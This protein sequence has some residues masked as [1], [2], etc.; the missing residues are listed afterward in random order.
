MTIKVLQLH[1]RASIEYKFIQDRYSI[2]SSNSVIALADGST[3]SFKS[4][5]W[6]NLITSKFAKNPSFTQED[7]SSQL[8]LA[9]NELQT[10]PHPLSSNPAIASLEKAKKQK[11]STA[12]FLG[13]QILSQKGFR[14]IFCGDTNLF[15]IH[16]DNTITAFPFTDVENLDRNSKFINTE[17][18]LNGKF[19]ESSLIDKEFSWEPND[20]VVLCTDALSRLILKEPSVLTE[21][22]NI[23]SFEEFL[24]FCNDKWNNRVLEEDDISAII[25]SN[26]DGAS[27]TTLVP[28]SNFSFPKAE[29]PEFTPT[30][31]SNNQ[32]PNNISAM[33][34]S[35]IMN[36]FQGVAK[37]FNQI[38]QKLKFHQLL[39]FATIF[40]LIFNIAFTYIFGK[41]NN[42]NS[43]VHNGT[44]QSE[45]A[46][47]NFKLTSELNKSQLENKALKA[48][49]SQMS[50]NNSVAVVDGTTTENP[51]NSSTK[52]NTTNEI[53]AFQ[54]KHGLKDDGS[55]GPASEK[56][57][58][59]LNK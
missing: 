4:E 53:K 2:D 5:I 35:Q 38:R 39:L 44:E 25:I 56:V 22:L 9:A 29:T 55:W 42:K 1:K 34:I 10:I 23:Q 15:Q 19:D 45:M 47:K 43:A 16:Q 40:L 18:L 7:F 41:S 50:K 12:T 59:K 52:P 17:D 37:D 3:Q 54:K 24:S 14:T 51:L 27:L 49:I 36:Q 28:P 32:D 26:N 8:Q 33:Q 6:A 31:L 30:P 46:Q 20:K 48:K 21:I 11:G 13:V 58:N 57:W